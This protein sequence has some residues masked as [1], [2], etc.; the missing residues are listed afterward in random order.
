MVTTP[1][2]FVKI[3]LI[4]AAISGIALT[5]CSSDPGPVDP[6]DVDPIGT[7]EDEPTRVIELNGQQISIPSPIQTAFLI[8]K[9]GAQFDESYVN[10]AD[11][12][13]MYS[14]RFKK[15]LNLGVYGADLGYVTIY[16]NNESAMHY[17][18]GVQS[19]SVD[20]DVAGAFDKALMERFDAN[21]GNQD[22]MLVL[23]S[24]A[25]RQGDA[26]LK[27]N[28]RAEIASLIIAG[29]W[30]EALY[31]ATRVADDIGSEDVIKRI[32]EQKQTLENLTMLIGE[33]SNEEEYGELYDQLVDLLMFYELI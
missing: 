24:Q 8:Q 27:G 14:T 13:S 4:A 32:G 28:D 17:L 1:K 10:E 29:G 26:Y 2:S 21:M 23:T 5:S 20:L 6:V 25:F 9:S 12:Y 7:I 15:G 18:A 31:F 19:L 30:I 22:S 33:Y 3:T 11:K 16:G